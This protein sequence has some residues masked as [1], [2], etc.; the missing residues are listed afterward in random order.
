MKMLTK[1]CRMTFLPNSL[2]EMQIKNKLKNKLKS[3]Q[4]EIKYLKRNKDK[5][6]QEKFKRSQCNPLK[7]QSKS[8]R[9]NKNKKIMKMKI[10]KTVNNK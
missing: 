10:M 6:R 5:Y 2:R 7:H 1:K 3:K 4:V 8:K 9:L